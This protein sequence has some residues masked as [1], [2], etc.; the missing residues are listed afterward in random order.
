[1]NTPTAAELAAVKT[2]IKVFWDAGAET[3]TRSWLRTA[4]NKQSVAAN[5]N[6]VGDVDNDATP[7][8]IEMLEHVGRDLKQIPMTDAEKTATDALIAATGNRR[9]GDKGNLV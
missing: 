1:M 7:S 2:Y 6:Y 9:Y 5:D 3:G 4:F 8:I